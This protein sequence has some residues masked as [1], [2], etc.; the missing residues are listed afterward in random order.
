MMEMLEAF[1]L[2]GVAGSWRDSPR[3]P[4]TPRI[5]GGYD[6]TRRFSGDHNMTYETKRVLYT[7]FWVFVTCCLLLAPFAVRTGTAWLV[8]LVL[9]TLAGRYAYKAWTGR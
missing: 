7:S 6:A 4:R 3:T 2:I 1:D 5:S 9:A 8:G